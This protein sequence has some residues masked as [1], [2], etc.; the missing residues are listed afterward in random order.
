MS[1][2]ARFLRHPG[3]PVIL[4]MCRPD[5]KKNVA[6]LVGCVLP[7][8]CCDATS[9]SQPPAFDQTPSC[10]VYRTLSHSLCMTYVLLTRSVM[11][12][13]GL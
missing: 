1:Q 7:G 2:V 12:C 3:R 13:D 6:A 5:A 9:F 4:A 8:V 10:S 11:V